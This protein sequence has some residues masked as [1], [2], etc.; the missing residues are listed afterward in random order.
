MPCQA[1]ICLGAE[2][3][4]EA[5]T[6]ALRRAARWIPAPRSADRSLRRLRPAAGMRPASSLTKPADRGRLLLVR[7]HA[8]QQLLQQVEIGV[9]VEDVGGVALLHDVRLLVLIA[10]LADDLLDQVLD[11]H[12]AGHAAVFVGHDRQP[13]V[14]LLHLA[15][16]FAA[17]LGFGNEVH[18]GLHQ[19]A[20]RRL[21]GLRVGH[22]QQVLGVHDP[23]DVIDV[24]FVDGNA[25][26][27]MLVQHLG[28]LG[29]GHSG[30]DGHDFR[31]RRH[32]FAHGL[33]AEFHHRLDQVAV[34]LFQ[35]ALFLSRF[36]QRVHGLGRM[37]RLLLGVLLRQRRHRKRKAQDHA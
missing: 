6:H 35:N 3:F 25:R 30:R 7:T 29:D 27:R 14:V 10:D 34:A 9:A 15:Q 13:D 2:T 37:L 12:Q 11:G 8:A 21:A 19:V 22:L 18:V 23:L 5:N 28:E 4:C 24:A 32:H 31:S 36:D 26:V 17:Q 1:R 16:Q 20:D 33:V